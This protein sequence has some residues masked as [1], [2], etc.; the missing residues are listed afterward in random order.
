MFM[1]DVV[2]VRAAATRAAESENQFSVRF[3]VVLD[4]RV[5]GFAHAKGRS[6]SPGLNQELELSVP[7]ILGNDICTSE[8]WV[9]SAFNAS[10][11]PI[12]NVPSG[13]PSIQK[14]FQPCA[15]EASD[16]KVAHF[17]VV[18]QG[19]RPDLAFAL[20]SLSHI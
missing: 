14:T 8:L 10:D 12:R 3:H 11:D 4:A 1:A 13:K 7:T 5:S 17:D 6:S 15:L 20:G 16:P 2:S 18:H 19:E 9:A